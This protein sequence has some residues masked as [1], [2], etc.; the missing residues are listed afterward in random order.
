MKKVSEGEAGEAGCCALC[1]SEFKILGLYNR[2]F[3]R[4]F[5]ETEFSPDCAV[6]FTG[7]DNVGE[8]PTVILITYINHHPG[9]PNITKIKDKYSTYPVAPVAQLITS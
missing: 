3:K 5:A 9:L 8:R 2:F 6:R 7:A 1:G 4:F